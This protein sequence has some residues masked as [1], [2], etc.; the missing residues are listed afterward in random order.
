[1]ETTGRAAQGRRQAA[2]FST[3]QKVNKDVSPVQ[4][5]DKCRIL[6]IFFQL[7]WKTFAAPRITKQVQGCD[8][9]GDLVTVGKYVRVSISVVNTV[10][11][12]IGAVLS[13]RINTR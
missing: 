3:T 5:G 2:F 4:H 12:T 1:M 9:C 8:L 7:R 10:R 13:E 6:T 11:H